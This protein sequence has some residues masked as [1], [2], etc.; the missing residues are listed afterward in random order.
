CAAVF[1]AVLTT[2]AYGQPANANGQAPLV[3][4][5]P[6]VTGAAA[7]I[8]GGQNIFRYD[9]YGDEA[10]WGDALQLHQA[11]QGSRFG[12]VGPGVSPKTALAL[13]LKVDS[14]ALPASVLNA[15]RHG[16]VNLDDVGVTLALLKNNAVVGVKGFFNTD[17]SLKSVGL[18]CAV[19]HSTVN[20]SIAPGVGR[21]LDGWANHDLNAGAIIGASP[22]LTPIRNLLQ[23]VYPTITDD[24]IR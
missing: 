1:G 18:T 24:T 11:I 10:F 8:Q 3:T 20:D 6:L 23:I 9:T 7:N 2:P 4:R 5:D 13:G 14:D 12:G 15:L 19:C 22:N 17:G 21:R 16:E